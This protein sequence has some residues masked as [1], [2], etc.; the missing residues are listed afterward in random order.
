MLYKLFFNNKTIYKLIEN[1]KIPKGLVNLYLRYQEI[2]LVGLN[3]KALK[4]I[5]NNIEAIN[6]A[7]KGENYYMYRFPIFIGN[8]QH[9]SISFKDILIN[10]NIHLLAKD[11]NEKNLTARTLALLLYE[12]LEDF[13]KLNNKA[14]RIDLLTSPNPE[15]IIKAYDEL[16]N[17]YKVIKNEFWQKLG[18]IRHQTI[19]HKNKKD[20]RLLFDS[21]EKIDVLD[22]KGAFTFIHILYA[23]YEVF[24]I[25]F[26]KHIEFHKDEIAKIP[27]PVKKN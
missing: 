22:I 19:A 27:Y 25:Q 14:F 7:L 9:L 12:F 11:Q 4:N 10:Q 6:K 17:V 3:K 15:L 8:W 23:S 5:T 20:V 18:D 2:F 26:T 16:K 1:H 24:R 21:I 13:Q